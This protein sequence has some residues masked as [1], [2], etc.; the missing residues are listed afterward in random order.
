MGIRIAICQMAGGGSPE[1]NLRLVEGTI[2]QNQADL[3]VFPELYLTGYGY[4]SFDSED[5]ETAVNRLQVICNNRDCAA[6]LGTPM[7]W[8]NGVTDSLLFITP[9]ETYRYDKLYPANFGPYDES[10]FEK[11]SAPLMVTFKGMKIGFEICYDVFFP[12]IHRFYAVHGAEMVIVISASSERSRKA[13]ETIL[14][15]RSLEN[16]VYT[17][18]C[19]HCGQFAEG[20]PF[21]GGSAL[22]S[23]LGEEIAKAGADQQVLI[24]YADSSVVE[25][26]REERPQLRDLRDDIHWIP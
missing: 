22:Y 5:A 7:Q 18:F 11:G 6:V 25:H 16:T 15:A 2:M 9:N 13:M 20:N 21:F 12:E 3:Y 4:D 26:A 19:N 10:M 1:E 24:T 17:V 23:P 14:P 8:Y